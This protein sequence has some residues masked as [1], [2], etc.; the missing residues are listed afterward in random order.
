VRMIESARARG[1][2][3]RYMWRADLMRKLLGDV[4]LDVAASYNAPPNHDGQAQRLMLPVSFESPE[5]A[6]FVAPVFEAH[7]MATMATQAGV[8]TGMPPPD[9][10][11]SKVRLEPGS[12]LAIPLI[13]GDA[14]AVASGTV[15]DVRPDGTVLGFGHAMDGVG[16]TALPMATG[17][18]HTV[19]PLVSISFKLGGSG[20]IQGS[21]VRDE[22]SG[23]AGVADIKFTSAPVTAD[24]E[25]PG[26]PKREYKY[27]VV[28]QKGM[29]PILAAIVV[30][31]SLGGV[32]SP[33]Q[34]NTLRYQAQMKFKAG[35]TL[36]LNAIMPASDP[37]NLLMS[38]LPAISIMEGNNHK[39][40]PLES[41]HVSMQVE[42]GIRIG[43][44][45]QGRLDKAQLAP[46]ETLGITLQ[47]QPY[48]KAAVEKRI[49][50]QIPSDLADGQYQLMVSD[51]RSYA[52][53]ML[54]ARP[55][56]MMTSDVSQLF[57]IVERILTVK[58]DAIYVMLQLPDDA[59]AVGHQEMP[60]LPSSRRAMIASPVSTLVTPYHDAI[61]KIVPMDLVPMGDQRFTIEINHE[62][63]N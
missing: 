26:Q 3:E 24:V 9:T 51:A 54:A 31:Q 27:E 12:V 37:V 50:L 14:S 4:T 32:Q 33:P 30:A 61:E 55:H 60:R 17:F 52:S 58:D 56:L 20:V 1:V 38:L 21:L 10:D 47:I 41:M 46:G 53:A 43:N 11:L 39:S 18:V 8:S 59:L 62:L 35:Y 19:V 25:M 44:I 28:H 13:W 34:E 23:V 16:V 63:A 2:S 22:N 48:G 7:G 40:L 5:L 29:T 45:V 42:N 49:E 15:T 57:G 6:Q 36:N